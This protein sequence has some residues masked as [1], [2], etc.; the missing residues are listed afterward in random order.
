MNTEAEVILTR[1]ADLHYKFAALDTLSSEL[2]D[3]MLAYACELTASHS[4]FLSLVIRKPYQEPELST[5]ATRNFACLPN[6]ESVFSTNGVEAED[7]IDAY[8]S[9]FIQNLATE[10]LL[11]QRPVI[12]NDP[13]HWQHLP[14]YASAGIPNFLSIP[15]VFKGKVMA[16]MGLANSK[17]SY[18]QTMLTRL[19][20][21]IS[22]CTTLL[23][24]SNLLEEVFPGK[25]ALFSPKACNRADKIEQTI[26]DYPLANVQPFEPAYLLETVRTLKER[27]NQLRDIFNNVSDVVW[28]ASL[29]DSVL[30]Y[31]NEAC[32]KLYG[33][34][35]SSF[36]TDRL[37]WFK[38]I[39]PEDAPRVL[40]NHDV[41][42]KNG[43]I[44][45]EYRIILPDG[46]TK[47]VLNRV[48]IIKDKQGKPVRMD[49]I[50]KDATTRRKATQQLEEALAK[51]HTLNHQL[52]MREAVLIKHEEELKLVN[53]Q[54]CE[55]VERLKKNEKA[56]RRAQQLAKV[57]NFEWNL[58]ENR[59]DFCQEIA[60]EASKHFASLLAKKDAA[61][62]L[63]LVHPHDKGKVD[64]FVNNVL[65]GKKSG[66]K[67]QYRLITSKQEI[68]HIAVCVDTVEKDSSGKVVK[69]S[70]IIQDV[71][72]TMQAFHRLKEE[73]NRFELALWGG[74]LG[75]WDWDITTGFVS[76]NKRWADMLGYALDEIAPTVDSWKNLLHPDDVENMLMV[77]QDHLDGK[78]PSFQLEHR[79]KS[80]SG[81]WVWVLDSGK[82]V[83]W[84]A[85][86]KP[87]QAVGTHKDIT[88]KKLAEE[89][90][91]KLALVAQKTENGV[92]ITDA[93]GVTE[94]VNEG[95]TRI[96]GYSFEEI[97]GK[98]PGSVLQGP[99]TDLSTIDL[100]YKH[101]SQGK[102][103]H[104]EILN[105][106]KS[107]KKYWLR[108][109]VQP[110][111]DT[112]GRLQ[113]F[114]AI[115]TDITKRK[116]V[117]QQLNFQANILK[118]VKDSVI[119]TDMKGNVIYYNQGAEAIFGYSIDEMLG[120]DL[121]AI[122][123]T[124][125]DLTKWRR[126]ID[127]L[128]NGNPF[129]GEWQ[130]KN[131]KQELIWVDVSTTLFM[132]ESG[133]PV[134]LIGV[135][136]DI[137]DRKKAEEDRELLIK[138]LTKFAFMTAHNLR[139]PLARILGL[140]SIFNQQ[141]ATDPI[142]K[143]ILDK[144]QVS[145]QELD[146]VIFKMIE[147]VNLRELR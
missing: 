61:C 142:N 11:T 90:V 80:K 134:G 63:A 32:L 17:T 124:T 30:Y 7:T 129:E 92:I 76:Y 102:E 9:H 5:L 114:V 34:P 14:S 29:D 51:E 16:V 113:R 22:T 10:V 44:G 21:F 98:K 127:Q 1:I 78:T 15:L 33:Y 13:Y 94:W 6:K 89:E 66:G 138:N 105:Y 96:S 143:L 93:E 71:T 108:L 122:Y 109:D 65:S 64:G 42:L 147:M 131:K 8:G 110:I 100:M 123:P 146:T 75:L 141:D 137:T 24:S 86:G 23:S 35:S 133:E 39:H 128:R 74:D 145:A 67:I 84:D 45:H 116:E 37:L 88:A 136:K 77:V 120:K 59:L 19:S 18:C 50:T 107:G 40:A 55:T 52:V 53:Q 62:Y 112:K 103:F 69:L 132:D 118:N 119:V 115:Q 99:E 70:G 126:N 28:S 58:L 139:G 38:V 25:E 97:K 26:A 60:V 27:E 111:F 106:T 48:W 72:S 57:G 79:L 104:T 12:H 4:A 85:E 95:F 140:V 87:L 56:L 36:Y 73:K 101:I 41:L 81:D 135:S 54:L 117:E 83:R 31:V 20:P 3:T 91:R 82:V 68:K 121:S 125:L 144:L 49:G 46:E 43:Y 47:W 2:L 130:A